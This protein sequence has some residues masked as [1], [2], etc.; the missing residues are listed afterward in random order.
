MDQQYTPSL[1]DTVLILS[2]VGI[3]LLHGVTSS[4]NRHPQAVTDPVAVCIDRLQAVISDQEGC[5]SFLLQRNNNA[6]A[7]LDLVQAVRGQS[8]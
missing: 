6:Q 8:L 1:T 2:S 7:L 4:Q 3:P 5:K